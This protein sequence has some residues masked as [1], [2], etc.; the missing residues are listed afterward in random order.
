[1]RVKNGN[2]EYQVVDVVKGFIL[3]WFK[4]IFSLIVPIQKLQLVAVVFH[5]ESLKDCFKRYL[6]MYLWKQETSWMIN[7]M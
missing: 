2:M 6:I 7:P 3:E 5:Q 4:A 1:M